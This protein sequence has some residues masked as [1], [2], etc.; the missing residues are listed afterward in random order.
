MG[1][2]NISPVVNVSA[3]NCSDPLWAARIS[4]EASLYEKNCFITL[5]YAP[6]YLPEGGT[7][8]LPTFS[9]L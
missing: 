1:L 2:C 9:S 6:E 3:A 5:T 8:L 4:N 7:S